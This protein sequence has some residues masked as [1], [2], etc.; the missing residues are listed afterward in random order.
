MRD[1]LFL[2]IISETAVRSRLCITEQYIQ[3]GE[4]SCLLHSIAV[5]YYCYRLAV[6]L[7]FLRLNKREL[8]RGALLHDYFLYDWH[9]PDKNRPLHGPYHPTAALINAESDFHLSKRERDIIKKHMFPLTLALPAF[10]ESYAVCLVDKFC[11]VCEILMKKPYKNREI[12][13]AI[14]TVRQTGNKKGY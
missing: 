1:S 9:I 11:S 4:T 13:S 6:K 2:K 14:E 8:I 12:L 3:H 10:K 5:A 7:G